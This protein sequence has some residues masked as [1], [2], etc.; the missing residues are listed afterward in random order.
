MTTINFGSITIETL[1]ITPQ[2]AKEMLNANEVN[3][4][5]SRDRVERYK[6]AMC[7]G[8]WAFIGDPI[9]QSTEGRILDGQHRLTAIEESGV[10]VTLVVIRGIP[11]DHQKYMDAGRAR[12][13]ADS[14]HMMDIK[15]ATIVAAAARLLMSIT[16]EPDDSGEWDRVV[17]V[18]RYAAKV[19]GYSNYEVADYVEAHRSLAL[20]AEIGVQASRGVSA[21]PTALTLV[22]Y[23]A[24]RLDPYKADAFM[25]YLTNG[26]GLEYGSPVFAVRE[27]INRR[28]RA[29]NTARSDGAVNLALLVLGWNHWRRDTRVTKIQLPAGGVVASTT[30]TMV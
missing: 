11:E 2:L 14:V 7:K 13:A 24:R 18:G 23:L 16:N 21:Q 27:T 8:A 15:N 26:I 25:T 9:R 29:D 28:N 30:L 4:K 22:H 3:R 10:T 12:K 1:S 6:R 17:C 19:Q 20:S 5:V